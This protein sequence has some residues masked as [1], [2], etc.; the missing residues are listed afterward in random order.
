[1][2]IR[3]FWGPLTQKEAVWCK[4]E[5]RDLSERWRDAFP[6][7]MRMLDLGH[8]HYFRFCWFR[9]IGSLTSS[10]NHRRCN[11]PEL[12]FWFAWSMALIPTILRSLKWKPARNPYLPWVKNCFWTTRDPVVLKKDCSTGRDTT[13]REARPI[14]LR[15]Y[16]SPGK[17]HIC[18][19]FVMPTVCSKLTLP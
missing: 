10:Q 16:W 6:P 5:V 19:S 9:E 7:C 8:D 3:I 15:L 13:S 14:W 17:V 18:N 4:R 2:N 1:M 11:P 12:S